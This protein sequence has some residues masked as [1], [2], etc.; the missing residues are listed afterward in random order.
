MSYWNSHTDKC[1]WKTLPP[2]TAPVCQP[3]KTLNFE[4]YGNN[5]QTSRGQIA[6]TLWS[7]IGINI[8]SSSSGKPP[9]LFDSANPTGG[10]N[11]LAHPFHGMILIISEDG[12][13]S[14]PDDKAS[15][16]T[17][18]FTFA[19][20]VYIDGLGLMDIE[21]TRGTIKLYSKANAQIGSF[22]MPTMPDGDSRW[23]QV[24][25]QNVAK[26][27]VQFQGSGAITDL[28]YCDSTSM[29][30]GIPTMSPTTKIPT[31][32]PTEMPTLP[33]PEPKAPTPDMPTWAWGDPHF[34]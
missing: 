24:N 13:Q 17:L 30:T 11:D 15:G 8:A 33:T 7:N 25:V 27:E 29:P 32:A 28:V 10:D 9:M 19:N 6:E 1:E 3:K 34:R 14:D 26:M 12:D 31:S 18:T 4:K 22:P 20:P 16:G 21:E 23:L 5:I 2:T